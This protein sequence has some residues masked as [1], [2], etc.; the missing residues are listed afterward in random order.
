M[1]ENQTGPE[2]FGRWLDLTMANRGITGRKIAKALKVHESAVSR[3]RAG[4]GV[5][6]MDSCLRLAKFLEVEEPV[7]L[8]VTAGLMESDLI[9]ADPLPMPEPTAARKAVKAQLAKIRGLTAHERQTL[10]DAYDDMKVVSTS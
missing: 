2:A 1:T 5:P 3:W 10:L 4:N 7:R 6:T 8:A 9:G